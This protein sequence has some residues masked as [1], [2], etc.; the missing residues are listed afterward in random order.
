MHD[1]TSALYLGLRHPANSL[2]PWTTFTTGRPAALEVSRK[3]A[4]VANELAALQGCER[5]TLGPSTL[6]LFWDLFGILSRERVRIYMDTDSYAIAQWGV[7][8]AAARGARVTRFRHRDVAVVR[9][10]IA[11]DDGK[12]G[13]PVIVADGFC[14]ACGRGAPIAQYLECVEHRGGY[15]VIDD[16]QALGVLGAR[17][18]TSAPYGHGGGGSLRFQGIESPH[19]IACSSLAKAFGTPVAVLAGSKASVRRFER[20]SETRTHCSA[21]SQPVLR[22]AERALTVNRLFGEQWRS[23]LLVLM[24]RLR[25]RFV[26]MGLAV[27]GG[28]FPVLTIKQRDGLDLS[29]LHA[30]LHNHGV[31][32]VLIR[33]C[34]SVGAGIALMVTALHDPCDIDRA[35]TTVGRAIDGA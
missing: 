4:F 22:A 11:R 27:A 18:R 35:V 20:L 10:L 25:D 33:G 26:A 19:V 23:H 32:G 14:P 3:A 1:F 29:A 34:S 28:L 13:R 21:P 9:D 15:V 7:E 16:T 31:G 5:A 24:R 30:R 2:G 12:G 6:H 17:P 8:R